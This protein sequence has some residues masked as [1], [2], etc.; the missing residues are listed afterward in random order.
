V[1]GAAG[2]TDGLTTRF[3][4]AALFGKEGKEE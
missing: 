3:P 1:A 4:R 2:G